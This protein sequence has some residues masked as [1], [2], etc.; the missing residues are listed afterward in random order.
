MKRASGL[1]NEERV[2]LSRDEVW[3]NG[4]RRWCGAGTRSSTPQPTVSETQALWRLQ[5][6]PNSSSQEPANSL[7][8]CWTSIKRL[9]KPRQTPRTPN[10]KCSCVWTNGK[11]VCVVKRIF[12]KMIVAVAG[13]RRTVTAGTLIIVTLHSHTIF[14][15]LHRLQHCRTWLQSPSDEIHWT[16]DTGVSPLPSHQCPGCLSLCGA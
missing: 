4:R 14:H 3:T 13:G 12:L 6:A 2:L 9:S 8:S 10:Q 5:K 1:T 16:H 11:C 7:N 15:V